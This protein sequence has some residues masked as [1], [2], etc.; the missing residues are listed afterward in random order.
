MLRREFLVGTGC[1]LGSAALADAPNLP[2]GFGG[3]TFRAAIAALERE[4]RGRLGVAILDTGTGGRFTWRGEERFAMC[5][6][7]KLPLVA[8]VLIRDAQRGAMQHRIPVPV[9][10]PPNSP[11]TEMRRGGF[12][13]IEEL[14]EAAITQSDNGAA[15]LL[16]PLVGGP[17]GFTR[18]V[19]AQGDAVSRLDRLEPMLNDVPPGDPHDTTS[20]AAMLRLVQGLALGSRLPPAS[21]ARLVGWL[22]ANKT[23]DRRLRAGLPSTWR[24]ADK[25]GA[26]DRGN[27][28]DV[29]ILWP[30]KRRPIIVA[31]YLAE[32]TLPFP[33]SSDIH[34]RLARLIA[35]AI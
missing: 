3:N 2:R 30:P 4:A 11:F 20:P 25:T 22:L 33:A 14:C 26:S 35:A 15:N 29:A 19:R 13:T 28:N 32:S 10:L 18:F 12:A 31:S 5:S 21:R 24:V 8:A 16:L 1:A 7:F 27:D 23:G 6:T 34:A 17:A 9:D